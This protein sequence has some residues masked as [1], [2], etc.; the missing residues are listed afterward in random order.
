MQCS[1]KCCTV[2]LLRWQAG[3]IG[4]SLFPMQCKC[5]ANGACPVLNCKSMLATF[6]GRSVIK[7]MYLRDG[8][9]GLVFFI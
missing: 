2:S 9:V 1:K 5:L 7:L 6:C 8:V 4:E 3:Q